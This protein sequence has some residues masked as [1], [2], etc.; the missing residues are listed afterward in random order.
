[1][2]LIESPHWRSRKS[3]ARLGPLMRAP[4]CRLPERGSRLRRTCGGV[5]GID[6]L[7]VVPTRH[8]AVPAAVL[9]IDAGN[10]FCGLRQIWT[11]GRVASDGRSMVR[12]SCTGR[13]CAA[14]RSSRVTPSSSA[15]RSAWASSTGHFRGAE[16]RVRLV[17]S[18]GAARKAF[19]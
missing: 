15:T 10:E 6:R 16:G 1:M 5:S 2:A 18:A 17:G 19:T 11:R 14:A 12:K 13:P 7:R 8:L 4:E 9:G 3:P